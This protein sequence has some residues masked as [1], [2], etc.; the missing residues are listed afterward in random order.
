M[1]MTVMAR[2]LG[3]AEN[4]T[5]QQ[6]EERASALSGF[7]ADALAA[8]GARDADEALGK[9]RA[10]LV[11]IGERDGLHTALKAQAQSG[12]QK[13]F[14]HELKAA[15]K[16]GRL[17]LGELRTVIPTMMKDE[18]GA[19]AV[20]AIAKLDVIDEAK[21]SKEDRK[22]YR[23]RLLDAVCAGQIGDKRIVSVRAFVNARPAKAVL[24]EAKSQPGDDNV[25][26]KA[27]VSNAVVASD[28]QMK[29]FNAKYSLR[30]NP[31]EVGAL[32]R[33]ETVDEAIAA[34]QKLA[35]QK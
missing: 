34:K 35:A 7:H 23:D 28:E 27:A 20:A 14:R 17:T 18:E 25:D 21:A 26:A 15:L 12:V 2:R 4:A 33:A 3:L 9:I 5:E 1:E 29:A 31:A 10:G 16:D 30:L 11:A 19:K 6:I 32:L 24:P 22:S 8:A 13:E